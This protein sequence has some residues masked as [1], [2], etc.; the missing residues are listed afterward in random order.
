MQ[1]GEVWAPDAT[2]GFIKGTVVEIGSDTLTV[3][4]PDNAC[5]VAAYSKVFPTSDESLVDDNCMLLQL[6]EASLLDNIKCR[7]KIGK[8]YTYTANILTVVN[9]YRDMAELYTDKVMAGYKG[10]S[11]GKLD[12]HTFAI[13]D[14]AYTDMS[15]R[16][17]S[18]AVIVSGESGA[19][20]TETTKHVLKYLASVYGN[21]SANGI[22]DKL[23]QSNPLLEAFGNAQT[24]RN[25]NS[26]RFGKFIEVNFNKEGEIV[27]GHINTYLLEKSRVTHQNA[28]E[29]SYHI[30][31]RLL[32]GADADLRRDIRLRDV[33]E[34]KCLSEGRSSQAMGDAKQFGAI[35]NALRCIDVSDAE[36]REIYKIVSGVMAFGNVEFIDSGDTRGGSKVSPES[37]DWIETAAL[38]LSLEADDLQQALTSRLMQTKNMKKGTTY[39]VPLK[40]KEA[41]HNRD[42]LCKSLYTRLFDHIVHNINQSL[43][44][45]EK[46]SCYIGVLDIA[47][48]EYFETN[49]FEQFC[50][51]YCNE[52]LQQFFNSRVIREEQELYR[53]ENLGVNEIQF[54]DNQDCIELIERGFVL[55]NEE[56]K[57]P[58]S[59]EKHFTSLLHE[60]NR[61]HF[62]LQLPRRSKLSSYR[63]MLDEEGFI[64]RHYAGAVCYS[65]VGW[66]DRNSDTLHSSLEQL[67]LTSDSVLVTKLY[68]DVQDV[69]CNKKMVQDSVGGKFKKQLNK[70][71]E[72]LQGTA[73]NFI[74]CIKP[75]Q[76]MTAAEFDGGKVLNQL[77]SLG[78]V[79]ALE[80]MQAGFPSRIAFKDLYDM[81]SKNL[82]D[83]LKSLHPRMFCSALFRAI[84][85]SPNDYRFGVTKIF[86]R[87]G[88]FAEV[89]LLMK[90]NPQHLHEMITRVEKWVLRQCWR[91]VQFAVLAFNK[92]SKIARWRTC[93]IVNIQKN[94]RMWSTRR[95]FLPRIEG[96]RAIK[97]S[98]TK[99]SIM[100]EIADKIK[101]DR[102]SVLSEIYE[103][104][105]FLE[106]EM[107]QL[108]AGEVHTDLI[109]LKLG[110]IEDQ[111]K[112]LLDRV[113]ETQDS[114]RLRQIQEEM[115][116][117]RLR[118]E[119]AERQR[120]LEEERLAEERRIKKELEEKRLRELEEQRRREEEEKKKLEEERERLEKE[121]LQREEE[122][123]QEA[124]R[125][126][127]EERDRMIA[128]S[129][130][131]DNQATLVKEDDQIRKETKVILDKNNIK[132]WKYSELRDC[133]NTSCD[134]ELLELA[135]EEFHRRLKAYQGWKQKNAQ[136]KKK[137][138]AK[139]DLPLSSASQTTSYKKEETES[140]HEH[141]LF[142]VPFV[143]P[144][145]NNPSVRGWWYAH[146]YGKWIVRQLEIHPEKAPLCLIAGRDD[147]KM[148]ELQLDETG[149]TK[150]KGSE[151]TMKEFDDLWACCGGGTYVLRE[152]Q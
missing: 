50:I 45:S 145:Y 43:P 14:K 34:Y 67:M 88:K 33:K 16:G 22:E 60:Q 79:T 144:S 120:K 65:T 21:T 51:N 70:L 44:L 132:D 18:Q 90:S 86:F 125:K 135:R 134:V 62:R 104:R 35:S 11:L 36:I 130:S 118:Q 96:V 142:K 121:R 78:M 85:M 2:H 30:F 103:M 108:K 149:L 126:E 91:R 17:V 74:R 13:A 106:S 24:V 133:I 110:Q 54:S 6:N 129:I 147:L 95:H 92:W 87:P 127:Q 72:K 122:E 124:L 8:I 116:A 89:D 25:N 23:L 81:Y 138:A 47:G 69:K 28:S 119:E 42:G 5:I 56:A 97:G 46:S 71:L 59:C 151:I 1:E 58:Q 20:K 141:R 146:F 123:R 136:R 39:M 73:T 37:Y 52:K 12:P 19:G 150:R 32:A 80:L 139:P 61:R 131:E 82:P 38:C 10:T 113:K 94:I 128:L 3:Q 140:K 102:N 148:C 4:T 137:E 40:K 57:L 27:G 117:E 31:Y 53:A 68:D 9:P 101:Y 152:D 41:L 112:L 48:F 77:T 105:D 99:I 7:F 49:S 76:H 63:S 83:N 100:L 111:V 115:E 84:G 107:G 114:D 75:N 55:L 66:L 143:Y 64:I 98:M 109:H 93:C 29:R 15:Y 26:S